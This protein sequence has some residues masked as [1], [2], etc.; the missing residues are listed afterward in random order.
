MS[1]LKK[2]NTT[3]TITGHEETKKHTNYVPLPSTTQQETKTP[4]PTNLAQ[5]LPKTLTANPSEAFHPSRSIG[6]KS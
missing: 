4:K 3:S 2:R 1:R 6:N 5:R